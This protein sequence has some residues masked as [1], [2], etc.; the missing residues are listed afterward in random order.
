MNA[1]LIGIGKFVPPHVVT[2]EDL[3]KRMDTSDEWIRTRT[4]IEQRHIADD[5]IDTS[6]M[7]YQA[8]V[9]AIEDAGIAAED[10]DLILVATVTPDRPFPSVA[11]VLQ[12]Q[13]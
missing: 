6:D 4:G 3:E 8:A 13:L 7:A 10:I 9:N 12:D 5:D 1:G 11:T 2:N